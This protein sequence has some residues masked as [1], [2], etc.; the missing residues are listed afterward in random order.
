ML[1]GPK[2]SD[3]DLQ[4]PNMTEQDALDWL[5]RA[6]L[7][8]VANAA[9]EDEAQL[10]HVLEGDYLATVQPAELAAVNKLQR[11]ILKRRLAKEDK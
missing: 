9:Q 2:V 5:V 4:A 10:E 6:R 11:S 1:F 3:A 8:H 7:Q